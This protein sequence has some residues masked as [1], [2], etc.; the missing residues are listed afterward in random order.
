M[1]REHHRIRFPHAIARFDDLQ[2]G[3]YG[4]LG[5]LALTRHELEVRMGG[6][7]VEFPRARVLELRNALDRFLE[8]GEGDRDRDGDRD[9]HR[10]DRDHDRDRDSERPHHHHRPQSDGRVEVVAKVEERVEERVEEEVRERGTRRK[11]A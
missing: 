11:R 4:T 6:D 9:D 8:L 5:L 2:G 1:S 7:Y 3:Q 10:H